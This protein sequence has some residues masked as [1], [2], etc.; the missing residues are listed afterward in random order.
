MVKPLL[1]HNNKIRNDLASKPLPHHIL[2]SPAPHLRPAPSKTN[3]NI[4]H[5][6]AICMPSQGMMVE[7]RGPGAHE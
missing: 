2:A 1:I 7:A 3:N 6:R 5:L 4:S